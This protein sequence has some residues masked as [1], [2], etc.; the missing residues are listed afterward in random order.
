MHIEASDQQTKQKKKKVHIYI[1]VQLVYGC[2]GNNENLSEG[3][4]E[5]DVGTV[6]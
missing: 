4:E 6:V 5:G 1:C 2:F 3:G